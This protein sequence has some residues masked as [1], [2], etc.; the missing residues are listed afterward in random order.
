M[1]IT[2]SDRRPTNAG[3]CP[4]HFTQFVNALV[5]MAGDSSGESDEKNAEILDFTSGKVDLYL[6]EI[7]NHLERILFAIQKQKMDGVS[8]WVDLLQAG[9]VAA[10]EAEINDAILEGRAPADMIFDSVAWEV[11]VQESDNGQLLNI[12]DLPISAEDFFRNLIVP[13]TFEIDPAL[14]GQ[15]DYALNLFL[16]RLTN[17]KPTEIVIQISRVLSEFVP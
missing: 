7:L 17:L 4:P 11:G 8:H 16:E 2:I 9:G 10:V 1:K 3:E 13:S 14:E 6:S 15:P 5:E 12:Q